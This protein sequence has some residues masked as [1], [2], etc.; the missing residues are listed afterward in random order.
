MSRSCRPLWPTC[1]TS[2]DYINAWLSGKAFQPGTGDSVL[3]RSKSPADWSRAS[4]R[5]L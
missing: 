3:F 2:I 1:V 5:V 4:V